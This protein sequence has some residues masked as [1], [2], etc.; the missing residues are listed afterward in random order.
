MRYFYSSCLLLAASWPLAAHAQQ[1]FA[2]LGV[3]VEILSLTHGRFPEYFE[4]DSLRRIGSVVYD[5]RLERVAYL[6]PPD[7]LVGHAKAEITA[8]WLAV[9]RLAEKDAHISPYVFCADN[10]IRYMD[11]DGQKVIIGY[12]DNEGKHKVI[13]RNGTVY[14]ESGGK[15]RGDNA[16]V[17]QVTSDLNQLRKDNKELSRRIDVLVTSKEIHNIA[18]RTEE[19]KGQNRATPINPG[20]AKE[21]KPTGSNIAYDPSDRKGEGNKDSTPRTGLGHE[22]TGHGYDFDQGTADY[23]NKTPNGIPYSEVNAV[24]MENRSRAATGDEKRTTYDG[25]PISAKMLDDTHSGK[26]P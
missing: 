9:D 26:N 24:N 8:R 20:D 19:H 23:K 1:P 22:L 16:Y 18:Q 4:N 14:N 3:Q 13:Y 7:S 12:Q 25:R 15:Y 2:E 5:T 21:G 6:L 11:P 17:R 10:A